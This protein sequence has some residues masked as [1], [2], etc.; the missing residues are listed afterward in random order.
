MIEQCYADT[1]KTYLS[2]IIDWTEYDVWSF[3]R[4]ERLKYCSLYDEGFK[5]IGCILCPLARAPHLD[6]A[7]WPQFKKAYVTTF[8]RLIAL[9]AELG[10]KTSYRTGEDMFRWWTSRHTT[11]APQEAR[12]FD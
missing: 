1:S 6:V 2:P 7:R 11:K 3:I 8:D 4:Q 9:R 12:L 10:L 5:R